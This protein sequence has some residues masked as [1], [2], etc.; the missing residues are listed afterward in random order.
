[1][2]RV[3]AWTLAV[4]AMLAAQLGAA[5]SVS[6]FDEIGT[7]GTAWLRLTFGAVI[8]LVIV[9]PSRSAWS[10]PTIRTPILLGIVSGLM[11]LFFLASIARLP[12]GT[13]I[14]IDFL[15]PLTVAVLTSRSRSAV[16]W[17]VIALAGVLILTHPWTGGVDP[18]GIL[19]SCLAATMWALYI[20]LMQRVGDRFTGLS[21]LAVMMPFA[22]LTAGIVGV[23]QAW[24]HL[25]PSVLLVGL[26]VALL[27]PVLVFALE[28]V[29]LRRLTTAAFGTLMA[30]EPGIG[31]V[32]GLIVLAQVPDLLQAVG[33]ALVVVAGIGAERIGRRL[34]VAA[35]RAPERGA[36]PD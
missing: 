5:A 3:P 4:G 26:G 15:G 32:V 7:S 14:A 27:M 23:P 9:R 35:V 11:T 31:T 21:G 6:L 22:A 33:I 18:V 12:L 25:T 20:L 34:P 30:L 8:L 17:P 1:M 29:A 36:F 16:V 13:A 28:M 10:W 19:F 2:E 24:G